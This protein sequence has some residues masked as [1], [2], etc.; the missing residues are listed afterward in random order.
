YAARYCNDRQYKENNPCSTHTIFSFRILVSFS[1]SHSRSLNNSSRLYSANSKLFVMTTASV[2]QTSVH[3]SHKIQISKLISYVSIIF[4]RLFGSG[5]G[6]PL[7]V[8]Q[9]VGQ[10]LTHLLQ[11]IHFSG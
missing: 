9:S 6:F 5:F 4:P 10:I 2:G 7:S 8:I 1:S 11:T 3:R